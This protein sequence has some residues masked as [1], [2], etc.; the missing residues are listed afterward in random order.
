MLKDTEIRIS[1]D[2]RGRWMDNVFIERRW[3]SL[4]YECVYPPFVF[5]QRAVKI[6][7]RTKYTQKYRSGGGSG[8]SGFKA[9]QG[10]RVL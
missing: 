10:F 9:S 5:G 2:G 1:M 3:R 7:Q 8:C 4:K 6:F